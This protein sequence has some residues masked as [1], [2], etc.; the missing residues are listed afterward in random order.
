MRFSPNAP[1]RRPSNS[2][3]LRYAND[4]D[5]EDDSDSDSDISNDSF[6]ITKDDPLTVVQTSPTAHRSNDEIRELTDTLAAVRLRASYRDPYEEWER[7]TK[8]EAL[9]AAMQRAGT[10]KSANLLQEAANRL[11][12]ESITKTHTVQAAEVKTLLVTLANKRRQ[13]EERLLQQFKARD[14]QL[15]E[16]I[17]AVIKQEEDK[18]RK[19]WEQAEAV[20]QQEAKRKAEEEAKAKAEADKKKKEE[21]EA[22]A[23]AKAQAAAQAR[24]AENEKKRLQEEQSAKETQAAVAAQRD[25]LGQASA[26]DEWRQGRAVLQKIKG[27]VM[28][29]VKLTEKWR[30]V[31]NA[32]RRKIT[33]KIGQITNDEAAIQAICTFIFNAVQPQPPHE[34]TLYQA[35]LSALAKAILLQ[36]ETEVSA[37]NKTAVPLA[38]VTALLLEALPGF[39]DALWARFIQRAGGWAVPISPPPLSDGEDD[40][41]RTLS[42]EEYRKVCGFRSNDEALGEYTS[43]VVGMLT[44]YFSILV[45]SST[46]SNPLPP[47]FAFPRLWSYL[48][49]LMCSPGI[50]KHPVAPQAIT[51]ALEVGGSQAKRLWGR[52]FQKLL[53]VMHKTVSDKATEELVGGPNVEGRQGRTR[54]QLEAERLL[55]S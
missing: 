33:A 11:A 44:L 45:T 8:E 52:Q 51:A 46:L 53:T 5:Y 20:R 43:R 1:V 49:R 50:L 55:K 40:V 16:R 21:E 47:Q 32:Q 19:V 25:K 28:P 31:Y 7:A 54:V 6:L 39:S 17:E 22:M 48:S 13:D 27:E 14:K 23:R 42:P 34:E 35:L 36:A 18:A 37:S 26:I 10:S 2:F 41:G 30:V 38:R 4:S 3:G 12:L 9:R 29:S 24:K 15:W